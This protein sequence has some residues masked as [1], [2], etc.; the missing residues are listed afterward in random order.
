MTVLAQ[1]SDPHVGARR[2]DDDLA[3][4]VAAV[5]ALR[6]APDALVITGDL[7]DGGTPEQYARVR[8]LLAP[9]AMPV[10]V[11]AGNHDDRDAL[12][13][14]FGAPAQ[15][16]VRCGGLR[17][18]ACHTAR[19]G[20]DEGELSDEQLAWVDAELAADGATPAIVALHHPPVPVGLP[21]L[22]AIG[23]R[24]ESS[25]ALAVVLER[26]PHVA[27]VVAGHVH[28]AAT[29]VLGRVPVVTCPSAWRMRAR[30]VLGAPSFEPVAEPAG[31]LVHALVGGTVVTHVQPVG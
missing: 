25:R 19:P 12:E 10:H 24:P 22:D 26:H 27:R 30:L 4:A 17:M 5:A 14:A 13:A 15:F 3:A 11:M 9:L 18:I 2:A 8:E 7:T 6:P 21:V 28:L 20:R 31:F 23:L 16:A 1:L 29:A